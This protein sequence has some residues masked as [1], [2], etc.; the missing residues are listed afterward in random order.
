M[1][2]KFALGKLSLAATLMACSFSIHAYEAYDQSKSYGAGT[3]VTLAGVD[4]EAKWW[5][6]PGQS[7][8][9]KFANDWETPWKTLG[10]STS[11][12]KTGTGQKNDKE[13]D[14][15]GGEVKIKPVDKDAKYPLYQDG[16]RYVGGDIVS[17][18][19]QDYR[20]KKG[21]TSAWCSGAAWAYAPGTGTAWDQ[22]WTL[23]DGSVPD[24]EEADNTGTNPATKVTSYSINASDLEKQERVLS[25]TP[26]MAQVKASTRTLDNALVEQIEPGRAENPENVKRVESMLDEAK[27]E[28]IFPQRAPEYTYRGF[29]QAVGKFPAFCGDYTDGRDAEG[30]CRKSLATMFA[31]FTQETGGHT[32]YSDIPEWR[33]GLV[34][35]REMGWTEGQRGGYNSECNPATWQGQTWPCGTFPNGEDKSY[36]GRGAKQLSYNYNYGPFSEAMFGT[37]RTLLDN[38]EQVADTWLNFASAVFF[39]VYPQPPKPSMLFTVDGTWQPNDRDK[40][41]GLVS[42]FG[43]TTQVINGGVECGG[44]KE[45]AQSLNRIKYYKEMAQYLGVPVPVDEVLGCAGMKQFD[46]LGSGA[47]P[48]S[49]EQD[50]S[51]T[52]ETPD[53]KTN[54]CKLVNY[55]TPFSALKEGDYVKC[56][57][58]HF[59]SV[60]IDKTR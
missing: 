39:F 18:N 60:T 42:G 38:P 27:F 3:K 23:F 59:P 56:V 33:Q 4:Y 40:G 50:W 34:Y 55:Q 44:S 48:L 21:V 36:F 45:I 6:N 28:Y 9:I 41:N 32:S 20:C 43:V 49:W 37:V 29:L 47:L 26:L 51:W 11:E 24:D 25:G 15:T 30:I 31:H 53:G 35:V 2:I 54:S 7:P 12:D 58:K 52:T 16:A 10:K 17:N 13:K 5:A 19:G 22:A 1:R 57:Q 14:K 46:A 8:A